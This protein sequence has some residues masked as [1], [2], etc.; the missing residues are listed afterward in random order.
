M[1]S[2]RSRDHQR[3]KR[4]ADHGLGLA[5]FAIFCV[6]LYEKFSEGAWLTLLITM[7][8]VA[9][10]VTIK[11]HYIRAGEKIRQVDRDL[12]NTPAPPEVGAP[13]PLIFDPKQPT[14]GIL[15]SEY[16]GLGLHVFFSIFRLLPMCTRT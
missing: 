5:C 15:V 10:C 13:A 9:V 3:G 1:V 14:A 11:K 12:M 2:L 16:N 6:M 7:S 8:L 4:T